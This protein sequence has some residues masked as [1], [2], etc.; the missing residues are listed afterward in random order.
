MK[1]ET[2]NKKII[3]LGFG[4]IGQAL[5]PLLVNR[6][7]I[8]PSQILI[9][10]DDDSS[11]SLANKFAI[12][13]FIQKITKQNYKEIIGNQLALDDLVIDV[14]MG[15][16]SA[17]MIQLCNEKQAFY[18]NASIEEWGES[19]F[20]E[21]IPEKR[22]N[23]WL[24]EKIL[25]LKKTVNKTAVLTHGANPGLVS[26]FVKQA[27]LNLAKDNNL[28]L[29]T[30]KNQ[31]EWAQLAST[32]NIKVIHIAEHDTQVTLASKR[33]G[34]FVNTWSIKGF[35]EEMKQPVE[36]GWGSH[37][38]HFPIDG[39]IHSRGKKS[40]IYIERPSGSFKIRS[41]TPSFGPYQGFL[42]THPET[43][44]ISSYLTLNYGNAILYR[45]TVLYAYCPCPDAIL[46]IHEL[47]GNEWV[48]QKNSRLIVEEIVEGVDELGVLLMGNP[49]GA[50]W[51]GSTLSIGS[52]RE[53]VSHNNAT[54]LQVVAGLISGIIWIMRHPNKGLMEPE[55]LDY[56][57][58]LQNALPYLGK[59]SG[60]YTDWTPL[61][62][63]KKLYFEELDFSDPWQFI[64]M[65][66]K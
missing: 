58:I 59:V 43:T 13:F 26:H 48:S 31:F 15:I 55:E 40:S 18:I 42:I 27:L 65:Q 39:K 24:R 29:T 41:W 8:L 64:N 37:E 45:P 32:L 3:L 61:Q 33:L 12:N 57:E 4:C 2:F 16:S 60:Y 56:E 17:S 1:K 11:I 22:T 62:N 20:E 52:A 53:L 21:H 46:S 30:P 6:L 23:Y 54:S 44:S 7:N 19:L 51:F 36:I 28:Q 9:I 47:Q 38:R 34:E 14:S 10:T 49:R 66:F 50:Y 5:L 63:R 35:I 25:K